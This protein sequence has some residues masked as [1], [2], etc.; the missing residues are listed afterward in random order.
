MTEQI[1]YNDQVVK[2]AYQFKVKYRDL[3][4]EK[5]IKEKNEVYPVEE[6][7]LE[8]A[9][10]KLKEM[11]EKKLILNKR[12]YDLSDKSTVFNEWLQEFDTQQRKMLN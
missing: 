9:A 2:E 8:W 5:K 6:D 1:K 10:S 3:S 4:N 7:N 11:R 12:I